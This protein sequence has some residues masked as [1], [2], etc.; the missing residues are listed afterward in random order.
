[1]AVNLASTHLRERG[2]PGLVDEA[3]KRHG[4][5]AKLL[6]VEVTESILLSD[7]EL[8]VLIAKQLAT[9]GVQMSIDD[10]GTG[11]SSMSYLKRLPI[12]SLK[13]DRSFVRD[14]VSDPD[15]AAIV[16]A[17]TALAHSLKLKVVAEGVE[18]EEQLAMLRSLACDEY[19][20]FLTSKAL[21]ERE[22]AN[23]LRLHAA[24]TIDVRA[25]L[26]GAF[27]DS[28]LTAQE[29]EDRRAPSCA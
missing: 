1:V 18:T 13:I 9:M 4:I 7:P 6:E 26:F 27:S 2:L 17:I 11:Y 3:L 22:F 14:L 29:E 23:L 16:A 25:S 21:D 20:G 19:Q 8:S 5:P 15:D 12:S 28:L 24:G 10:F